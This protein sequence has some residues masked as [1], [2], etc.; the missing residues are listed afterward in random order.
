MTTAAG[1]VLDA[2]EVELGGKPVLKAVSLTVAAGERVVLAGPSGSGKSTLLRA[3]AGLSAVQAGSIHLNGVRIDGLPS[4][5]RDVAMMFQGYALFPHLTV[6]DNLSFGLRARGTSV[7][8]ATAQAEAVAATLGLSALLSRRPA[9]LSGGERQR[10]ALGRALLRKP[11]ALLLDEPL[12]S[13]DAQLRTT[14][15]AEI[16]RAHAGSQAAMLLVTHDQAEAMALADRL[17]ILR[18]GVLQQLAPPRE[19]YARPANRFVAQFLGSP[20]MN[21]MEVR[22]ALDGGLWWKGARLA[23]RPPVPAALTP[24]GAATLGLRPEQLSLPGSRWAPGTIAQATLSAQ[25]TAIEPGGDQ[26]TL[27]FAAEGERLAVKCEP[28]W[29]ARVGDT[30]PLGLHLDSACWFAA[31]GEGQRL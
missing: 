21:L 14:A 19:I 6:L 12:S 15:R 27:W 2:V 13:L 7:A 10:V 9:A 4:A 18:D 11:G 26:Q 5:R 25:L 8:E 3:V 28:E 17:G 20:A 1:L 16:V 29:P 23:D 31:D 22:L 30:V 24:G